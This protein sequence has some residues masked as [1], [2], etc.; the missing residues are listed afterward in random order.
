M[1]EKKTYEE[2]LQLVSEL[3]INNFKTGYNCTE[4]VFL[5]LIDA[6]ALDIPRETVKMCIG[7]G[8]G[9]GGS[10]ET[11]GALSGAVMAN[12][13]KYG[14]LGWE[15][16]DPMQRGMDVAEKYYRRYNA[17]VHEFAKAN[18]AVTCKGISAPFGDWN[19]KDRKKYCMKMIGAT[20]Q[21]AYKYLQMGNDE[22]FKLPYG[23][24]MHGLQ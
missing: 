24:N 16:E 7:F 4:C 22:A 3:A 11:C 10:G 13:A 2:M 5:A 9:I 18:G 17:M 1:S 6:G 20:A 15:T 21:M 14:R 8:G 23:F 19:C 12:G